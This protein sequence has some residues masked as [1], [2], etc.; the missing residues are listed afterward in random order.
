MTKVAI[1]L[2]LVVFALGLSLRLRL[3]VEREVAVAVVRALLQ[4]FV[5]AL[6][7]GFVFEQLAWSG[8]FLIVM[9]A[10]ATWTSAGR[11]KPLPH[12]YRLA[13][14]AIGSATG[15]AL[16]VLFGAGAFPL[17][18]RYL[19]PIGGMLIGNSMNTVS[20]AAS[21]MRDEVESRRMEIE[22]RLALA[23]TGREALEPY[24]RKAARNALMPMVDATKNVGLVTLP[25]AF[26]G[27]ILGGAEPRDAAEVQ[28]VV[29]FMLLGAVAI[30]AGILSWLL[31]RLLI[32]DRQR[33]VV[34]ETDLQESR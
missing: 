7:I 24:V 33:L 3:R 15:I 13:A 17:E 1:A 30:A 32:D 19:I 5:V 27:M 6:I 25:G 4:M 22:A 2:V 18:P 16:L 20:L 34:L 9:L 10:V 14:I 12:R 11:M 23:V 26:V 29:M 31:T 28:L 8:V 21:R